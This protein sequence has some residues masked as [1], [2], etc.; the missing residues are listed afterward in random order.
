M[1]K[2]KI[3]FSLLLLTF[4]ISCESEKDC[5]KTIVTQYEFSIQTQYGNIYYPEVTQEVPCDFPE[6]ETKEISVNNIKLND[7]SYEVLELVVIPDTGNNTSKISY[8]IKLNNL[9]N[10]KV[11]GYPYL[12]TNTN[13]DPLTVSYAYTDGC[14]EIEANSSCTISYE[15]EESLQIAQI[16]SFSILK[17]EYLIID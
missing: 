11:K 4:I 16:N 13:N 14:S 12:T 2:I 3:F 8:K 6:P 7:F 1:K 5:L 9:S 10:K 15:S 17:V